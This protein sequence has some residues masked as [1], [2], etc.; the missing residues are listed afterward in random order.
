MPQE[1]HVGHRSSLVSIL[2][3]LLMALGLGAL[4][5]AQRLVPMAALLAVAWAVLAMV[6]GFALW[7][8]LEW[9]RRGAA[10]LLASLLPVL[11]LGYWVSDADLPQLALVPA[12]GAVALLLSWALN[13]LNSRGVRQ[14][15]V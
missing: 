4:L 5:V 11:L 1:F 14:E 9:A 13:R 2:G 7:R 6:L 15:F 8:R 12:S 10:W 3:W